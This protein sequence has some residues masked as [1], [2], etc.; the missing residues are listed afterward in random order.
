MALNVFTAKERKPEAEAP[1]KN[2]AYDTI[3]VSTKGKVGIIT[4]NRPHV[5]NAL[6]AELIGEVNRSLYSF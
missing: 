5:L 4:L 3:L 2:G 6:N 1:A